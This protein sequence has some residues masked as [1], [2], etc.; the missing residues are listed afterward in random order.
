MS[1]IEELMESISNVGLLERITIDEDNF[2]LSGHRRYLACKNLGFKTLD[3]NKVK[4]K[5]QDKILYL[6]H[7]NKQRI[8]SVGEILSEYD[9][10]KIYFKNVKNS[11]HVRLDISKEIQIGD[12]NLARLL[13]IRK[14]RKDLIEYIE[15]G[16][17]SI[18]Q[19]Y[20]KTQQYVN[21]KKILEFNSQPQFSK[22]SKDKLFRFFLKSSHNMNEIKDGECSLI[23]TSPPFWNLRL[24]D[25]KKGLGNEDTPDEYIDNLVNHLH[26]ECWRILNIEGNLFI[27]IGDSYLNSNLQNIPHK[28]AIKLQS[29]GWIQRNSIVCFRSNARPSSSKN[30]LK[31]SYTMLFHFVKSTKYKYELTL[32]K[33]SDNTKVSN[34]PR[35]R[36]TKL[37]TTSSI[38][39]YIPNPNGKNIG[40]F[41][42]EDILQTAVSHQKSFKGKIEHPALFPYK[43]VWLIIN[44]TCVL[45][46]KNSNNKTLLVCDPFAGSLTV[47]RVIEDINKEQKLNIRFIGYDIKKYW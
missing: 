3:V 2:I 39:P 21:E 17:L 42:S 9:Q 19:A 32:S 16:I 14:N 40:D 30:N 18:N 43:L 37:N 15:N 22:I 45:P 23:I 35:H 31:N 29:M 46:F 24:Y 4:I 27:E 36:S 41:L 13:Y 8:K 10:L 1:N 7:Y 11:K 34:P 5:N 33:I 44:S 47:N 26:S 38:T 28:V 20:T 25:K 6:I 12:G